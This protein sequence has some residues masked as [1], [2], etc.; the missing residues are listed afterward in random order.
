MINRSGGEKGVRGLSAMCDSILS[1]EY[2]Y[3]SNI[4]VWCI[5]FCTFL[6]TIK[7]LSSLK[8]SEPNNKFSIEIA[9]YGVMFIN[10]CILAFA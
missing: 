2:S 7:L 4:L 5:Y 3:H 6:N 9:V 1:T 10:N 8:L